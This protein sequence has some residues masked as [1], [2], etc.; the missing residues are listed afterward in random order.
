MIPKTFTEWFETPNPFHRPKDRLAEDLKGRDFELQLQTVAYWLE[1]CWNYGQASVKES[2]ESSK[3]LWDIVHRNSSPGK[4]A[5]LDVKVNDLVCLKASSIE[6]IPKENNT[7][8]RRIT[9]ILSETDEIKF[10]QL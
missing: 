3:N 10:V 2:K 7:T 1:C 8:E 5:L 9:V 4:P 6:V